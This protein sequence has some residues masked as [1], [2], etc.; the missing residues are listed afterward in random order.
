MQKLNNE[1]IEEELSPRE[2]KEL[3]QSV[4]EGRPPRKGRQA[5]LVNMADIEPEE[6]SFLWE[7]Y[8]PIG[9]LTLLEGDPGAGKTFLAL[10][11]AAAISAGFPLPGPDGVPAGKKE[12]EKVLYM[13][14]EDGL[15]DTIRPRLDRMEA[16]PENV[17]C[18]TGWK[19]EQSGKQGLITLKDIKVI[20]QALIE[21]RPAFLVVDPLQGYLGAGVD[22][23]RANETRPVMAN[24]AGLAEK[25]K[26]ALL[27]V[28]HLSKAQSGRAIYRGMGSIDFTAAA[29]SIMLAGQD[30]DQPEKRAIIHLKSSTAQEGPAIGFELSP[31]GFFWTGLSDMT[32]G[33]LLKADTQDEDKSA[34]SEAVE[35]LSEVLSDGPVAA[36][37]VLAEAED[38]DISKR[39]LERAKTKLKVRSIKE[40]GQW[41]WKAAKTA[42]NGEVE[43]EEKAANKKNGDLGELPQEAYKSRESFK[44]A[45]AAKEN[46]GDIEIC[47][48]CG[49]AIGWL[50]DE[51]GKWQPMNSDY[52]RPHKCRA[53]VEGFKNALEF[54][55]R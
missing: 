35:F 30:P 45:K 39:T 17:Y 23:H 3:L 2:K 32:A 4:E 51:T 24:L 53:K 28:R 36:K 48:Y 43:N 29:R 33:S 10:Q 26:V 47:K 6:V 15:N 49:V 44:A 52:L 13:S 11:I 7:P 12:P 38:L 20:E 8:L 9:K 25:Y 46:D 42:K 37:Q 16:D 5:R 22:M 54:F 21:T 14:A 50:Q 31:E 18:L 40:G 27:C 41:L 1:Q 55:K 19:D 34:M